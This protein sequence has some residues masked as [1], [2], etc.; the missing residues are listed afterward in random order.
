MD[1]ITAKQ[2]EGLCRVLNTR[3]NGEALECWTRTAEGLRANVGV[4]YID[5]AYGGV[6][7]YRMATEGGGVSDVF[8]GGHTTRRD[9]YNRMRAFLDGI[10]LL[11]A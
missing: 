5:G 1:R 11:A 2:L 6:A 7:L 9:L 4:F 3:V 8:S 10:D